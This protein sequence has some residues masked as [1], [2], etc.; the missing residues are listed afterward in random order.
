VNGGGGP[1]PNPLLEEN[2]E[3]EDRLS[4]SDYR[5][6]AIL[7]DNNTDSSA[8]DDGAMGPPIMFSTTADTLMLGGSKRRHS[9]DDNPVTTV[10][11]RKPSRP[12]QATIRGQTGGE[13]LAATTA[14]VAALYK[15][16]G[17]A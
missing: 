4:D 13:G 10:T 3:T 9:T 6:S 14:V 12:P 17:E 5:L 16:C 8:P 15:V 7:A 2:D 1:T 11:K